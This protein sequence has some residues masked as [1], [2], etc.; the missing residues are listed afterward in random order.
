VVPWAITQGVTVKCLPNG[1]VKPLRA[2][3]GDEILSGTRVYDWSKPDKGLKLAKTSSAGEV[4]AS[5]FWDCKG[6]LLID[7]LI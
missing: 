2:Q 1:K 5:V 4:M 6:I 3:F 7:F